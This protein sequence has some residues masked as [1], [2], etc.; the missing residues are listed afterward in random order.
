MF[1][2]GLTVLHMDVIHTPERHYLSRGNSQKLDQ[3]FI[4]FHFDSAASPP[5]AWGLWWDLVLHLTL[6]CSS[7]ISLYYLKH[8]VFLHTTATFPY[9]RHFL[10]LSLFCI[11]SPFLCFLT[12]SRLGWLRSTST[13]SRTWSSCCWGTRWGPSCQCGQMYGQ[14]DSEGG[15]KECIM[16]LVLSQHLFSFIEAYVLQY[17]TYDATCISSNK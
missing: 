9:F 15:E 14:M 17:K 10:F 3:S 8:T 5:W 11:L 16:V 2:G 4:F 6:F 1:N 13:P 7:Q 12:I